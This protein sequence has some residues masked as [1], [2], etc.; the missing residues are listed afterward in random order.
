MELVII[1]VLFFTV[2]RDLNLQWTMAGL[3][4]KLL[5][6]RNTICVLWLRMEIITGYF[7]GS[8]WLLVL[9]RLLRGIFRDGR[10]LRLRIIFRFLG[11]FVLTQL[12]GW[13]MRPMMQRGLSRTGWIIL[14]CILSMGR[15]RRIRLFSGFWVLWSRLLGLWRCIVRRGLEGLEL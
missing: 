9:R 12:F 2:F 14:I 8:C 7:R 1:N 3:T 15:C 10:R 6:C 11:D 13:I 4:F 5:M